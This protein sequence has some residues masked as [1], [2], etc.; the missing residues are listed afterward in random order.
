MKK[1][2]QR[3]LP[4]D[5]LG[6]RVLDRYRSARA[7]ARTRVPLVLRRHRALA[8]A[9]TP[10]HSLAPAAYRYEF[11]LH[12]HLARLAWLPASVRYLRSSTPAQWTSTPWC[13]RVMREPIEPFKGRSASAIDLVNEACGHADPAAAI[14]ARVDGASATSTVPRGWGDVAGR[15][16]NVTGPQHA[17]APRDALTHLTFGQLLASRQATPVIAVH[18]Q[19]LVHGRAAWAHRPAGLTA[20]PQ[21][22]SWRASAGD[23]LTSLMHRAGREL[24]EI[25]SGSTAR[26]SEAS[27]PRPWQGDRNTHAHHASRAPLYV[28][29]VARKLAS[30]PV[31]VA[32]PAS[33]V[34]E[35]PS[36]AVTPLALDVAQLSEDVYRHI[37]RSI[38]IDRERRGL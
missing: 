17:D 12:V 16:R 2:L 35:H 28:H 3:W 5:F 9:T 19:T 30:P 15:T 7:I 34:R 10:R 14:Q 1:K 22:A 8:N 29:A 20:T 31:P 33:P 11:S 27:G 32:P 21:A 24:L 23:E 6:K 37:Q 26:P 25:P 18:S 36:A 4:S 38:R 13:S